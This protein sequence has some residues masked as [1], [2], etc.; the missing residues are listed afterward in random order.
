MIKGF[1]ETAP[2]T[3]AERKLIPILISFL[4]I[5]LEKITQFQDQKLLK[6]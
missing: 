5:T 1:N 3:D 2:L 4:I 6:D